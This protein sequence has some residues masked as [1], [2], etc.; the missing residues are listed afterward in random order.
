MPAEYYY[1]TQQK[2]KSDFYM[3]HRAGCPSLPR[4]ETLNFIGSLYD[5]SQAVTVAQ[6]RYGKNIKA[7]YHCCRQKTEG[8]KPLPEKMLS[9]LHSGK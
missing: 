3:L 2:D 9:R 6:M 7:C 4:K 1:V 8:D 5:V